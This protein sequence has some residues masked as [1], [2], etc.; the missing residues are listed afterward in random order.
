MHI[1]IAC[2][3][4]D[5]VPLGEESRVSEPNAEP[6]NF[7]PTAEQNSRKPGRPI[8]R[9]KWLYRLAAMT[10]GP[11]VLFGILEAGL[12]IG[13]YGKSTRFFL[14][15]SKL[16]APGV[17]ID[18]REFGRWVF[19]RGLDQTPAP[20]PFI[21]NDDK[22]PGTY[23]IFVLGESAAMGFPEPS[24]SFG[25]VLEAMLRAH[26]PDTNFEVVN[27][28]MVA[29]NS[30]IVLSIARECADH[31]PDLFVVHLGN[32]EVVGP[33]G[34]AGVLG[35]YS[36][37]RQA[38]HANL[39]IRRTRTGQ[40]LG[41]LVA[42]LKGRDDGPR[43]WDGM[44]MFV[45]S[46][47]RSDDQRLSRTYD[48]FRENLRDICRVGSDAKVPVLVCTI[49]VNLKDSA[50]FGSLHATTLTPEQ[51]ANWEAIYTDGVRLES[52]C[53]FAEAIARYQEAAKIDDQFADLEF[54][55]ARC[56][57]ALGQHVEAREKYVG[58][59]ELDTLRFRSD[60]TINQAIRNVVAEQTSR[61][62]LL[63]DAERT[64]EEASPLHMP[65]E[66]LFLEHVHMNF[67]GNYLLALTVFQTLTPVLDARLPGRV[68]TVTLTEQQCA[69][70]LAYTDWNELRIITQVQSSLAQQAPF[71]S[72]LD[73]EERNIRW[74]EKV[75][76]LR[77]RLDRDSLQRAVNVHGAAVEAAKNDWMIRMN[78]AS[79][80]TEV[81][82][83]SLAEEQY[84]TVLRKFRHCFQ[85]HCK[86]GQILLQTRRIDAAEAHFREAI[87]L[88][89][90]WGESHVGL[91]AVLGARGKVDEGLA[92]Y[93]D[94]LAKTSDRGG[95]LVDMGIYLMKAS[96]FDSAKER[97]MEAIQLKPNNPLAHASLGDTVLKLGHRDEAISHY[98]AALR[99]LP[100]WPEL[101]SHLAELKGGPV[102]P[103]KK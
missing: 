101:K 66:D 40:L 58:A 3:Q 100:D 19:P 15:G 79:L 22:K 43:K 86:L 5:P 69:E 62:V 44:T 11:V 10:L 32:N 23:R 47:V 9:R 70:R 61:G 2:N 13:G 28:A 36:L 33:Y 65:G 56:L 103:L 4:S 34:A 91:A 8:G 89:P 31:E 81:G 68:Q 27:A 102:V 30:H 88:I 1:G 26:Y 29:I 41:S 77:R 95:L 17:S 57:W 20:V 52:A 74:Q 46:Q 75:R 18:N 42:S 97:L 48:H 67:A 96:R 71:T 93:E 82:D 99:I 51:N 54:R 55:Q 21:L 6:G 92:I 72:Q 83:F 76:E 14:D 35:S 63:A 12:R 64:F 90:E 16:E 49:P 24:F 45:N 38:I 53:L 85:A 37:S 94:H 87:G 80:L 73:R 98:E 50:P 39:A 60:T 78:Y 7:A 25:R 84:K 59:R